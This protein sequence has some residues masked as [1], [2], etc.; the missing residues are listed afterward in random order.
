M[1]DPQKLLV[2]FSILVLV[3]MAWHEW[4]SREPKRPLSR[5]EAEGIARSMHFRGGAR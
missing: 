5:D 1:S 3:K 4:T 2:L